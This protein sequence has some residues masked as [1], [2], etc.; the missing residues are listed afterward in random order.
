MIPTLTTDRLTLRPFAMG[1]FP[2]YAAFLASDEAVYMDG[3]HGEETAWGWFCHDTASWH[4]QGY[5]SLMI[6]DRATGAALGHVGIHRPPS[7]PEVEMGWVLYPAGRGRGAATEAAAALRD[8][9]TADADLPGLV[10]YVDPRNTASI[11]LAQ[12]LGAVRD[13]DAATPGGA[14]TLV[15]RHPLPQRTA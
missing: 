9:V 13:D 1:D 15:F 7:F 3:P 8:H 4:L 12:R 11:R 2:A 14:P 5:G 6:E 10:S